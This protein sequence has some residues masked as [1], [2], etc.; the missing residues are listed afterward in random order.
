MHASQ[1]IYQ[2]DISLAFDL[3]A[4]ILKFW[5]FFAFC[6]W[7]GQHQIGEVGIPKLHTKVLR[8]KAC[9]QTQ[10]KPLDLFLPG[11]INALW[12][13]FYNVA[14]SHSIRFV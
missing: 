6:R 8:R 13:L 14:K 10:V 1:E 4:L 5:G 9:I 7:N 2:L 12:V 3:C 11:Y